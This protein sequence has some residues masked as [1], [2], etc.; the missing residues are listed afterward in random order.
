MEPRQVIKSSYDCNSNLLSSIKKWE[1]MEKILVLNNHSH[2]QKLTERSPLKSCVVNDNFHGDVQNINESVES[3]NRFVLP[4]EADEHDHCDDGS[5]DQPVHRFE[6]HTEWHQN[7]VGHDNDRV[8]NKC[9]PTKLQ[10]Q[11][12]QEQEHLVS[13]SVIADVDFK[14]TQEWLLSLL[15]CGLTWVKWLLRRGIEGHFIFFWL[16][17]FLFHK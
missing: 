9:T 6:L 1:L 8:W 5:S 2:C 16:N 15:L 7:H 13:E 12:F 4:L 11:F 10:E 3:V 17:I 14:C